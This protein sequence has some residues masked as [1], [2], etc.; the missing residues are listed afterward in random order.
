MRKIPKYGP[1]FLH[2]IIF[3]LLLEIKLK[4]SYH[5]DCFVDSLYSYYFEFKFTLLMQVIVVSSIRFS[6]NNKLTN[7]T[8]YTR[9][10][11]IEN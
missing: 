7:E 9:L 3:F 5:N 8:Q 4:S 10:N 11:S 6:L 2:I 1:E